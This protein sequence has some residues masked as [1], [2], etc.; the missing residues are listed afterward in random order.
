MSH[1]HDP[2]EFAAP[3][4]GTKPRSRPTVVGCLFFLVYLLGLTVWTPFYIVWPRRYPGLTYLQSVSVR[5]ALVR[6]IW[7]LVLG[8]R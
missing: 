2:E 8:R 4:N 1:R 7:A 3:D 6:H 5:S